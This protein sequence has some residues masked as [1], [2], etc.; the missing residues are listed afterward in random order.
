MT[1]RTRVAL[2][3]G[4]TSSEHDVSCLTAGSVARAID[5][6]RFEIVGV[7]I[8]LSG[9]WVSVTADELRALDM[10]GDQLPRLTEDHPDCLLL[11]EAGSGSRLEL[12]LFDEVA[13]SEAP[14]GAAQESLL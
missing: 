9:R 6:G 11:N 3:F 1:A 4:G 14:E 2:V 12:M 7:G 10:T 5:T 8:T 13:A